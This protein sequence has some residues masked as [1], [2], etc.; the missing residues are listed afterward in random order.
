MQAEQ[1]NLVASNPSMLRKL[2]VSSAIGQALAIRNMGPEHPAAGELVPGVEEAANSLVDVALAGLPNSAARFETLLDM[3]QAL[4]HEAATLS[5]DVTSAEES[6]VPSEEQRAEV[7]AVTNWVGR[8]LLQ[9]AANETGFL[10]KRLRQEDEQAMFEAATLG[11]SDGATVAQTF[12]DANPER[13]QWALDVVASG[14]GEELAAILPK[15]DP[16]AVDR[17]RI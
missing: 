16:S 13:L 10:R 15:P 11:V 8:N 14:R 2:V 1:L 9:P 4:A 6:G 7:L 3:V 5:G 17:R 12:L